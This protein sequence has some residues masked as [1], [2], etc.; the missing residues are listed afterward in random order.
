MTVFRHFIDLIFNWS[1]CDDE[2]EADQRER[3]ERLCEA[4]TL[5]GGWTRWMLK[6]REGI[7]EG[8][9]QT[10]EREKGREGEISVVERRRRM[11]E[12]KSG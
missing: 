4:E 3:G 8:K 9:K 12:G 7:K 5:R 11:G 1:V 10:P 6:M 2:G